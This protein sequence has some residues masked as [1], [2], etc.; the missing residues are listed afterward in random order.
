MTKTLKKRFIVFTMTAVTGL[1]VFIVI[2]INGLN[3]MMLER[4]SDMVMEILVTSDGT[5]HKMDFNRPPP[6]LRPLDMDRMRSS[7]FFIVRSDVDGNIRD[8]NADQIVSID[9]ETAKN[10]ALT[11]WE[12]GRE[13]GRIKGYKFFVKEDRIA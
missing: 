13:S 11:V 2:T 12:T 6:F 1:L 3:W 5:F 9:V 10:Y 4:Q 8:I 7:R